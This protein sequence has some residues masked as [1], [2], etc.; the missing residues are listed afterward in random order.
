MD[1]QVSLF[2][3]LN[4]DPRSLRLDFEIT[5]VIYNAEFTAAL[6]Q[7]QQ[8]YLSES[9][10]LDLAACWISTTVPGGIVKRTRATM[11]GGKLVAETTT[12]LVSYKVDK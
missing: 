11:Q 9:E 10:M 8:V 5:L 3:S 6:R 4:L 12:L 2:G 1:G 7:L